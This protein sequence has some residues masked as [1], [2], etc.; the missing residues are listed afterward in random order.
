[1]KIDSK[2]SSL[3]P[4]VFKGIE[5]G[6]LYLFSWDDIPGKD[7]ERLVEFL[8]KRF[9]IEWV[10]NAKID[11]IDEGKTIRVSTKKN[12]LSFRLSDRKFRANLEIDD[13]RTAEY[14]VKTEYGKRNIFEAPFVERYLKIFEDIIDG[15]YSYDIN[16]VNRLDIISDIFHPDFMF[17]FEVFCWDEVPGND[18]LRFIEYLSKLSK[19]LKVDQ[20]TLTKIEKSN[21]GRVITVFYEKYLFNWNEISI[22][23]Q[24]KFKEYLIKKLDIPW[25]NKAKIEEIKDNIIIT[26]TAEKKS[27]TLIKKL[28]NGKLNIYIKIIVELELDGEKKIVKLKKDN[29]II[30]TLAAKIK[31]GKRRIYFFKNKDFLPHIE[32]EHK[33]KFNSYFSADIDDFLVW[34][35]E[36]MG[37]TLKANWDIDTKRRLIAKTILLYRMRGTKIGLEE[38]LKI[39]TGYNIEIIDEMK[40]FQVGIS[41]VGK[42]TILGG[43]RPNHFIVKVKMPEAEENNLSKRLMIEE[44]L[45]KE[46]P[47]HTNYI[48]NIE[49]T[50]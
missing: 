15:N 1:M 38:Y 14:I 43:L 32:E 11:K 40:S 24:V 26:L 47:V 10:E 34:F 21:D 50:K 3:I 49:Y 30:I 41:K 42:D 9:D 17:L 8:K 18:D 16:Q 39:C 22:K 23:D 4:S 45:N 19:T 48:L 36:W 25:I 27:L 35:A 37:L 6:A 5:D 2:Y 28:E 33:Q 13:G 20:K 44:L 46:K 29:D 7:D 31:N 12:S